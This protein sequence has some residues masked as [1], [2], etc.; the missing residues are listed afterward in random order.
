VKEAG[1]A[2]PVRIVFLTGPEGSG[3]TV[4]IQALSRHPEAVRGDAAR[5]G[6]SGFHYVPG[7]DAAEQVFPAARM[8]VLRAGQLRLDGGE[9]APTALRARVARLAEGQPAAR[10]L[11]FKYSTPVGRAPMMWPVF[12]PF[13]TLPEFG[14]VVIWR[15]PLDTVYSGFRRFYRDHR[16]EILGVAAAGLTYARGV[17]HIRRQLAGLP[18]EKYLEVRY[19]DLVGRPDD[20]I[21][22]VCAFAGVERCPVD[23]L[24]PDTPLAD[25]NQ[26]WKRALRHRLGLG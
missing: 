7:G 23:R 19:E 8:S 22:A 13:C 4:L 15:R 11:F 10:A 3:T 9:E 20:V 17:R 14:V 21:G 16:P 5:Y 1:G 26:K 2:A 6:H 24:M 12:T 25:Q 18:R